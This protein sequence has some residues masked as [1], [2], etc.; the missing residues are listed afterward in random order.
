MPS[1]SAGAGKTRMTPPIRPMRTSATAPRA[2]VSRLSQ[3]PPMI[4]DRDEAARL[5]WEGLDED[6][7][8]KWADQ[9]GRTFEV[10]GRT[11]LGP[12]G[13]CGDWPMTWRTMARVTTHQMVHHATGW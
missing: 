9:V 4:E 10:G 2:A 1:P 6:S 11:R 7:R 13:S 12:S 8:D 3:M 5:W